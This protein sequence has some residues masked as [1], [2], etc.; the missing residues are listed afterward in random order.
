MV[1]QASYAVR[2]QFLLIHDDSFVYSKH[3][4]K[5]NPNCLSLIVRIPDRFA[6]KNLILMRSAYDQIMTITQQA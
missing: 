3:S 5:A 4:V 2:R 1:V 6:W